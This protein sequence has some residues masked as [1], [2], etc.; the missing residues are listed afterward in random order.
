MNE[1]EILMQLVTAFLGS[2]GFA[3]LFGLGTRHLFTSS[4]GGM[5]SWGLYLAVFSFSR[6]V[7]IACL[8]A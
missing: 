7:F 1:F 8:V 4:L 2:L 6:D 5:L 3:L